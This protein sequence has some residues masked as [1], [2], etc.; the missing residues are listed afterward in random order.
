MKFGSPKLAF[1]SNLGNKDIHRQIQFARLQRGLV[2]VFPEENCHPV[3]MV[4]DCEPLID[5]QQLM[6][7]T[8]LSP[9]LESTYTNVEP[10]MVV[11]PE[12]PEYT[13]EEPDM[14]VEPAPIIEPVEPVVVESPICIPRPTVVRCRS[15]FD[16]IREAK[17]RSFVDKVMSIPVCP[18]EPILEPEIVVETVVVEIVPEL[19][20]VIES[21]VAVESEL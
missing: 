18:A 6:E 7:Y 11:E 12:L 13:N 4:Y 2:S 20:P 8:Q 5:M 15:M 3:D 10:D 14:V 21:V 9:V 16:V 19:E 17:R 1:R